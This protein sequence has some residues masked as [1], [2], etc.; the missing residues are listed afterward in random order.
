MN[1]SLNVAHLG[2]D[3]Y[4]LRPGKGVPSILRDGSSDDRRL[5][6]LGVPFDYPKPLSVAQKIVRWF[7]DANDDLVLDFFAGSG[8]TGHAV[9]AE[10]RER[11]TALQFILIQRPEAV[12]AKTAAAR[13]G[14]TSVFD[15]TRTRL[16]RAISLMDADAL[17]GPN[18][19][20]G[21]RTERL[22]PCK[23]D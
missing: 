23:N 18:E 6:K 11:N 12:G 3:D 8:T 10:N 13:A 9:L 20:R 14:F 7:T 15:M 22:D 19:D 21:F 5:S 1:P 4:L 16:Q 17:P 2:F